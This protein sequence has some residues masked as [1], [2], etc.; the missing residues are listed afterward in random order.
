M[1]IAALAGATTSG[2]VLRNCAEQLV[3]EEVHRQYILS[4]QLMSDSAPGAYHPIH[5]AVK[6]RPD[7]RVCTREGYRA[8]Q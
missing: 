4:F 5:V 6:N 8:V 3:G 7:L 1:R 2:T